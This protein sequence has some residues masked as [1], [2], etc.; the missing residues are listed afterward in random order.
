[1]RKISLALAVLLLAFPVTA[2]AL[3][4]IQVSDAI[5]GF[6]TE[7]IVR[8]LPPGMRVQMHVLSP[9]N[10]DT[11]IPVTADAAGSARVMIPATLTGEPG[12]YRLLGISDDAPVTEQATFSTLTGRIDAKTS[13]ITV[14][15]PTLLADGNAMTLV[16]VT[17]R[18]AQGNP[19][20]GRPVQ[21]VGSR[22]Q[23]RITPLRVQKETDTN[24]QQQFAIQTFTAGDITVRAMDLLS[25][26]MLE[27]AGRILAQA[28]PPIG[29]VAS[30]PSVPL[31]TGLPM[32]AGDWYQPQTMNPYLGQVVQAAGPAFGVLD[33]FDITVSTDSVTAG[34]FIPQM[35]IIAVDA[36][37]RTVDR[38]SVV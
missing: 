19:L 37:G 2:F 27:S 12:I 21:L 30:V 7:A 3:G 1:M 20:P 10:E 23:D 13:T 38:K 8:G 17:L 18:D 35:S 22:V 34:D 26:T 14:Q 25:G 4:T 33:H 11:T 36:D 16:T 6:D 29:G 24:G 15:N 5:A 28:V 9:G 31:W 32:G